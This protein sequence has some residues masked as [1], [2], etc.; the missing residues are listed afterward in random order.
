MYIR[1]GVVV[2]RNYSGVV[3]V[4]APAELVSRRGGSVITAMVV[5]FQGIPCVSEC[6][7][8]KANTELNTQGGGLYRHSGI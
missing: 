1:L 8:R 6:L 3:E 4:K 7:V 2:W 5:L